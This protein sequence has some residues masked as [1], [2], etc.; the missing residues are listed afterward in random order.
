[1]GELQDR[2]ALIDGRHR[3]GS[4]SRSR[5]PTCVRGPVSSSPAA[6]RDTGA[7]AESGVARRAAR[8]RSSVPTPPTKHRSTPR[9]S[10]RSMQLGGLDILVNNAGI[11]VLSRRRSRTPLEDF[12]RVMAVNV[13]GA[14]RYAQAS[15]PTSPAAQG[16]HDPHGLRRRG[17]RRGRRSASTRCRRPPSTCCRTCSPIEGRTAGRSLQRDRPGDTE[18][19]MRHMGPPGEPDRPEDDPGTWPGAAGR[20]ASAGPRMSPRR[21]STSRATE[22][23]SSTASCS[24]AG[25]WHAR[26]LQHRSPAGRRTKVNRFVPTPTVRTRN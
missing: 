24:T 4:A 26:R 14:F 22:P 7:R 3:P 19:G 16:M 25:R 8:R 17:P 12:D 11:G 20:V 21:R 23:R 18:P 6:T 13:R 5:A 15:H 10:G 2:A 1:M 9:S